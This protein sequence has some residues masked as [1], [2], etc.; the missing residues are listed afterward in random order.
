LFERH[1]AGEKFKESW[2]TRVLR[3]NPLRHL[4]SKWAT[5]MEQLY[6]HW[7]NSAL[8]CWEI[9]ARPTLFNV[10]STFGVEVKNSSL[11]F[12]AIPQ[13]FYEWFNAGNCVFM[14]DV[15]NWMGKRENLIWKLNKLVDILW[16][17]KSYT[18][19]CNFF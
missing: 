16:Q 4:T 3:V 15:A 7:E 11:L 13:R 14:W 12:G 18:I 19:D 10:F 1:E 17:H 8:W 9:V 6:S 2:L 5:P